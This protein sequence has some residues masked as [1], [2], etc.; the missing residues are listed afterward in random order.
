[1]TKDV[2][3]K[4]RRLWTR[5]WEEGGREMIDAGITAVEGPGFK[6]KRAKEC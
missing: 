1:M 6:S 3:W 4:L 2:Y 5:G